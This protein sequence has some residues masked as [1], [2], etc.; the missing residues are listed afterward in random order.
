[1]VYTENKTC[2]ILK[3]SV[4]IAEIIIR[5]GIYRLSIKVYLVSITAPKADSKT[6]YA[7]EAFKHFFL[8]ELQFKVGTV[9]TTLVYSP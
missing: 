4:K 3:F 5:Q 2:L 8:R 7:F 6:G 9:Q 1:M